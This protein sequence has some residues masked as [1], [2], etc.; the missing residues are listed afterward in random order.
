MVKPTVMA[1]LPRDLVDEVCAVGQCLG[2]RYKSII[3]WIVYG[4]E[5]H[6][7]KTNSFFIFIIFV[8]IS[9]ALRYFNYYINFIIIH[10]IKLRFK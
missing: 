2:F 10:I 1:G 5:K 8:F 3:A 4:R 7:I 9:A 6:A